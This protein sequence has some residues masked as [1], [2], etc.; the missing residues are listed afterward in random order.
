MPGEQPSPLQ[1]VCAAADFP[2]G[3]SFVVDPRVTSFVNPDLTVY[4]NRPPVDDWVLV[5]ATT[6]LEPNGNGIAEGALYD[7]RGRIGRS[8]QGLIVES[9]S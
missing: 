8:V 5:D 9:R 7:R 6:Y 3:I 1:R 4:V 2:N